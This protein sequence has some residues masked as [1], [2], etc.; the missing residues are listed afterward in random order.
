MMNKINEAMLLDFYELTMANGYFESG[1]K[2][3]IVYFDLFYRKNPD[4]GGYALFSGL[5]TIID[6]IDHL[7]F[8]D[9]DIE[10][11][12]K[13]NVFSEEFLDFLSIY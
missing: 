8:N 12:W 5:D 2:D 11:F 4:G 6:F 7:S 13:K 3:E 10:F 1:K 9:K